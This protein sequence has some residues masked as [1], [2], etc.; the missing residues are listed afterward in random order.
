M[1]FPRLVAQDGVDRM[2]WTGWD[3]DEMRL[4]SGTRTRNGHAGLGRAKIRPSIDNG[5]G[6]GHGPWRHSPSRRSTARLRIRLDLEEGRG[7]DSV[8]DIDGSS[9]P[10]HPAAH[11]QSCGISVRKSWKSN[12]LDVFPVF[13]Q[14]PVSRLH[15]VS[16][17]A[18]CNNN[19]VQ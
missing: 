10:G 13:G 11:H 3:G 5:R 1:T 12:R 17:T 2:G 8:R 19:T 7:R 14:S 9:N 6:R 15:A 16:T 18:S 4:N